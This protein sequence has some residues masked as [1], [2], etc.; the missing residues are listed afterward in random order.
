MALLS[1]GRFAV[2]ALGGDEKTTL[3]RFIV[4]EWMRLEEEEECSVV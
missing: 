3:L 2:F 4:P 1:N